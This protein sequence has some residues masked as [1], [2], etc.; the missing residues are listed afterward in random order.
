MDITV[1]YLGGKRFEMSARGHLVL[2]DQPFENDGA[3]SGMTP[4]EIFLSSVGACAGYYAA[5]YLNTRCLNSED[6]EIRVSAMKGDKPVRLTSIK[7]DIVA[8]GLTERHRE[9]LL[10]AVNL[11]LIKNTLQTPPHIEVALAPSLELAVT[12]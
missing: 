2:S 7:V 6:L 1:R 4:P 3:D 5:E 8:P 10:R 12:E 9:G 11:C